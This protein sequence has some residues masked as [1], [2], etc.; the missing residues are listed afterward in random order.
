MIPFSL[1]WGGF[2]IFWEAGARGHWRNTPRSHPAPFFF[3]LWGIPFILIGQYMI[4]GHF[5]YEAWLKRRT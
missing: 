2:A 5:A 4:C 1:F 3:L